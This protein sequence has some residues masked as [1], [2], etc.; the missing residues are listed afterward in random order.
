MNKLLKYILVEDLEGA[1][2]IMTWGTICLCLLLT[3]ASIGFTFVYELSL[4]HI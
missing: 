1:L 4:I 3:F 2:A